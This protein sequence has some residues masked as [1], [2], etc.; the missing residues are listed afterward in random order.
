MELEKAIEGRSCAET[1]YRNRGLIG[2]RRSIRPKYHLPFLSLAQQTRASLG[3]PE[4][5]DSTRESVFGAAA[6]PLLNNK[7]KL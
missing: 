5:A 6:T 7:S 2:Q 1:I 3:K 4:L